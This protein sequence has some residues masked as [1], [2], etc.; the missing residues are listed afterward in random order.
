MVTIHRADPGI[1]IRVSRIVFAMTSTVHAVETLHTDRPFVATLVTRHSNQS[2]LTKTKLRLGYFNIKMSERLFVLDG[3]YN[4]GKVWI[5]TKTMGTSETTERIQR[6]PLDPYNVFFMKIHIDNKDQE[7]PIDPDFLVHEPRF[8]ETYRRAPFAMERVQY[9]NPFEFKMQSEIRGRG[10]DLY[11]SYD[12]S[13]YSVSIRTALHKGIQFYRWY[14]RIEPT[15]IQC[16]CGINDKGPSNTLRIATLAIQVSSDRN[17]VIPSWSE[18]QRLV[19][20]SSLFGHY[21]P[22]FTEFMIPPTPITQIE[23]IG[24]QH[25]KDESPLTK[26]YQL[27]SADKEQDM[28]DL[29]LE[30]LEKFDCDVIAIFNVSKLYYLYQ[31]ILTFKNNQKTL[32]S[33]FKATNRFHEFF[34]EKELENRIFITRKVSP[35]KKTNCLTNYSNYSDETEKYTGSLT[36][37]I[38]LQCWSKGLLHKSKSYR[39]NPDSAHSVFRTVKENG[40]VDLV[41]RATGDLSL[42][43]SCF[44][45]LSM[46]MLHNILITNKKTYFLINTKKINHVLSTTQ[47]KGGGTTFWD[48]SV[49]GWQKTEQETCLMADFK[50]CYANVIVNR[51]LSPELL[52]TPEEWNDDEINWVPCEQSNSTFASIPFLKPRKNQRV[53]LCD[54]V[55]R[56]LDERNSI[57][58]QM[59]NDNCTKEEIETLNISQACKK[60]WANTFFGKTG[61]KWASN[62]FFCEEVSNCTTTVVRLLFAQLKEELEKSIYNTPFYGITDS[63]F[64]IT[65][66]KE[67]TTQTIRKFEKLHH[68]SISVEDNLKSIVLISHTTWVGV[69]NDGS[70]INKNVVRYRNNEKF[71]A[72]ITSLWKEILQIE[73]PTENKWKTKCCERLQE[74]IKQHE[75]ED[76]S[77]YFPQNDEKEHIDIVYKEWDRSSSNYYFEN[78]IAKIIE[79]CGGAADEKFRRTVGKLIKRAYK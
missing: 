77:T 15:P 30:D 17:V 79:M 68:T 9:N 34:G 67:E 61:S 16:T 44:T 18:A 54:T 31:R 58:K 5:I 45:R 78:Q 60:L 13:P 6:I 62:Q 25:I 21:I 33:F 12:P 47:K 65:T 51:K 55:Q 41:L 46:I 37:R 28:I 57:Q 73:S 36:G 7:T 43:S 53:I 52:I 1:K 23:F 49:R 70:F 11:S 27:E 39:V 50:S 38:L 42:T 48:D 29:F 2:E 10:A 4:R 35:E 63:L 69:T 19:T 3:Y 76:P 24:H 75:N 71:F 14:E 8:Y 32:S 20:P 66:N 40:L 59:K 64:I 22:N 26:T 72:F 56:L 74:Y